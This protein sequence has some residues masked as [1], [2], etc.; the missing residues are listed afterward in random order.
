M[1]VGLV[2]PRQPDPLIDRALWRALKGQRTAQAVVRL[3]PGV[4]LE[5]RIEVDGQLRW[6]RV[7]GWDTR[8]LD[9]EAARS[10]ARWRRMAGW[11]PLCD[12]Q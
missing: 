3:I 2:G 11:N 6:S 12:E 9:R 7:Y 5:L 4:G 8:A 1:S 10:A